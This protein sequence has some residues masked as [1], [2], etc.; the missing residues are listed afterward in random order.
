MIRKVLNRLLE[1]AFETPIELGVSA[2]HFIIKHGHFFGIC[3]TL[4]N[5]LAK[6]GPEWYKTVGEIIKCLIKTIEGSYN[7]YSS[8]SNV[9][10]ANYQP[11]IIAKHIPPASETDEEVQT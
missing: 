1:I 7:N 8:A 9:T 2:N 10:R 11:P 3:L 4:M 6:L 5:A